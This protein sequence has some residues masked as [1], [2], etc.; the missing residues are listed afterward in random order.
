MV[1]TWQDDFQ[2]HSPSAYRSLAQKPALFP[3]PSGTIPARLLGRP[4]NNL[5]RS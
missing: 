2:G 5:P 1:N 4:E 3:T